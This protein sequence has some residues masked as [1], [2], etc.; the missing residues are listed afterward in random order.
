MLV[1]ADALDRAHR[2]RPEA[3]AGA[4]GDAEVHRDA[5]QREIE[6]AEIGQVRRLA[7]VGRAEQRRDVGE[8]PFAPV[9]AR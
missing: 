6:P 1:R 2:A 5:D 7:A 8:R 4:V 3:R 9:A